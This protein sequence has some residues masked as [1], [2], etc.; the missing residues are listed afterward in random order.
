M[1]LQSHVANGTFGRFSTS[2]FP[3]VKM[4]LDETERNSTPKNG[5]AVIIYSP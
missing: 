4:L 3:S 5:N 1:C 2:H